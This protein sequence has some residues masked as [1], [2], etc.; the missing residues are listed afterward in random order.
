MT[1]RLALLI[2][3]ANPGKRMLAEH[4]PQKMCGGL[5]KPAAVTHNKQE[6]HPDWYETAQAL[7]RQSCGAMVRVA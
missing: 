4:R 7:L 3:S 6:G 5:A 1:E 2:I